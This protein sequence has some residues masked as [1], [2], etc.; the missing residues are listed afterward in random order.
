MTV[1]G[2]RIQVDVGFLCH[3]RE[4]FIGDFSP[5]VR[6]RV[7]I[8][9]PWVDDLAREVA[10][11]ALRQLA[12][13]FCDG[14][15]TLPFSHDV[16][17][18]VPVKDVE[19]STIAN[20]RVLEHGILLIALGGQCAARTRRKRAEANHSEACAAVVLVPRGGGGVSDVRDFYVARFGHP[21]YGGGVRV[22]RVRDDV[23]ICSVPVPPFQGKP[24]GFVHG[25]GDGMEA[26]VGTEE[27]AVSEETIRSGCGARGDTCG[28]SH[29]LYFLSLG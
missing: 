8:I 28:N 14:A 5:R 2:Y 15:E 27:N 4:D 29:D 12:L 17:E 16:A 26:S 21:C 23:L 13:R 9:H 1:P 19:E 25:A 22:H 11:E 7:I 18:V 20:A 24:S 6:D 3:V 10:R